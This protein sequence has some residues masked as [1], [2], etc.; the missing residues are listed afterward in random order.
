M[1]AATMSL[2]QHERGIHV[3]WTGGPVGADVR[4]AGR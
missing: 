3:V 4:A 1:D 2:E